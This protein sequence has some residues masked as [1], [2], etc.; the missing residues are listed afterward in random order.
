M[1]HRAEFIEKIKKRLL[2]RRQEML[3]ELSDLSSEKVSDDQVRDSGDEALS[4]Y[5]ERLKTS[6]EQTEIDELNLI[7]DALNRIS[8]GEYGICIDCGE[9]ISNVRL[10]TFPYAA[11]CI[12][13]QEAIEEQK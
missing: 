12:V 3:Q 9:P 6:L 7:D 13:C 10:E 4:L 5:M 11:R 1:K 8:K 2:K